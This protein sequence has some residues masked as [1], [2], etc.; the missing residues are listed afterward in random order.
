MKKRFVSLLLAAALLLSLVPQLLTPASAAVVAS[1]SCGKNLTWTLDDQ[2]TLTISGTGNMEN[3]AASLWENTAPWKDN[4][5]QIKRIFIQEGV[6]SIGDMAFYTANKATDVTLPNSLKTIGENAFGQCYQI[7]KVTIP[8]GVTM[9]PKDAFNYCSDLEEVVLHNNITEIGEGAFANS[10]LRNIELPKQLKII[11]YGAFS[12]CKLETVVIPEGV[13]LIDGFGFSHMSTLT[14]ITIPDS[15]ETLGDYLFSGCD[16]LTNVRLPQTLKVI[17]EHCFSGCEAL[18]TVEIPSTVTEIRSF[19]FSGCSRLMTLTLPEGVTL[20]D[21]YAFIGCRWLLGIVVPS[22]VTDMG[23]CVFEDCSKLMGAVV[24][25]QN[26]EFNTWGETEKL[27]NSPETTSLYG[28]VGSTTQTYAQDYGYT[29]YD[30]TQHT[31]SYFETTLEAT[32]T[33]SGY[34]VQVCDCGEIHEVKLIRALG[35]YYQNGK[36]I[37]CGKSAPNDFIDLKPDA[38]YYNPVLWAYENGI[39]SGLDENHFGPKAT[40]TRGQV[41][42]FLWNAMGQ[43]EPTITDCPFVDVKPG[44]YYYK[45]MLWALETGVTSGKDDTHFAP[46]D[47]CTRGQVVTFIWNA[48]GKP[49]ASITNTP[50]VDVKPG[51][52]YYNAMLWALE[53]GV[54]SGLD[55]THFGPNETCTRGQVVTFL[56]NTLTG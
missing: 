17:P 24:L 50:F 2:G 30:W 19:A 47:T 40:C 4:L 56:Y 14:S 28:Y 5:E 23:F 11:G 27:F 38:Y 6:T 26:V 3:Y 46:N 42:T 16:H 53:N 54:T 41:V 36:C 7:K 15:V 48:M 33:T 29:F 55:D 25:S 12:Q 32:C 45:A 21:T 1:G 22:T 9:I 43:P 8:T 39:T 13:K 44:K 18:E 37:R 10:G 35:H 34:K 20:I 52:Y 49:A 51:K 31:H